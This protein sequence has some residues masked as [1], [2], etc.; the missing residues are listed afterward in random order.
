MRADSQLGRSRDRQSNHFIPTLQWL[1][2][3]FF[4]R[5]F[6]LSITFGTWRITTNI[7]NILLKSIA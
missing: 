7:K 2:S 6:D 1:D 3:F 4:S 5:A